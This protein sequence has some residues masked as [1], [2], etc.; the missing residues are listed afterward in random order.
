[1]QGWQIFI[2]N[3]RTLTALILLSSC[4]LIGCHAPHAR[5]SFQE[6]AECDR[7]FSSALNDFRNISSLTQAENEGLQAKYVFY[8]PSRNTC[9]VKIISLSN[10]PHK[11]H[12][13]FY[14]SMEHKVL[15]SFDDEDSAAHFSLAAA[16]SDKFEAS[17]RK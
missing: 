9:V 7:E 8:S 2:K 13:W 3:E 6:K 12:I 11:S 4:A 16:D 1:M 15:S 10:E 17:L 14:D 5:D